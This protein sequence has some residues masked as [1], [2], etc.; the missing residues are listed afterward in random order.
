[1]DTRFYQEFPGIFLSFDG[2]AHCKKY[3]KDEVILSLAKSI[4][5]DDEFQASFTRFFLSIIEQKDFIM[6]GYSGTPRELRRKTW[7]KNEKEERK[8]AYCAV[9]YAVEQ[10]LDARG[11]LYN[12]TYKEQRKLERLLHGI[13]TKV[14]LGFQNVDAKQI[15]SQIDPS[16]RQFKSEYQKLC[17]RAKGPFVACTLCK[18]VCLY[19]YDV[20]RLLKDPVQNERFAEELSGNDPDEILSKAGFFCAYVAQQLVV[21]TETDL[22]RRLGLCYAAQKSAKDGFSFS[23]QMELG[24][25]TLTAQIS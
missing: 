23:E 22:V 5:T 17:Q 2:C 21:H 7:A 20:S 16:V 14:V 11:K 9:L 25:Q 15:K 19:R 8:L 10:S 13:V 3:A 12:W 24:K 1:M 4:I 6:Q 18:N